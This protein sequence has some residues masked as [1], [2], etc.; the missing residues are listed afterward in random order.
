MD[1]HAQERLP[2]EEGAV[3]TKV[4][5]VP[6][7]P[8]RSTV[9]TVPTGSTPDHWTARLLGPVDGGEAVEPPQGVSGGEDPRNSSDEVR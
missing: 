1:Q 4:P 3:S 8:L 2:C 7:G 5:T 9:T 6:K